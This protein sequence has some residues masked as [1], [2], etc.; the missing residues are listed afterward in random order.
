M[1]R[2]A[3]DVYERPRDG[4]II[5]ISPSRSATGRGGA[6]LDLRIVV[7]MWTLGICLAASLVLVPERPRQRLP[8]VLG[9]ARVDLCSRTV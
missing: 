3:G 2:T 1:R 5:G 9:H 4:L 7:D 8:E 6:Q